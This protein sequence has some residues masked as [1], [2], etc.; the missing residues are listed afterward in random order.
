MCCHFVKQQQSP[1][2]LGEHIKV[3]AEWQT[4]DLSTGVITVVVTILAHTDVAVFVSNL[5]HKPS[6][7]H[8][9][10]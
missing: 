3:E 9:V 4:E 8:I 5:K 7:K 10:Y 6:L 1:I 2:V